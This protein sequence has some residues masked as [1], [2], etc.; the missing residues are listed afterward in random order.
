MKKKT[1]QKIKIKKTNVKMKVISPYYDFFNP[2]QNVLR[3]NKKSSKLWQG[4]KT[5]LSAN[6]ENLFL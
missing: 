6:A 1:E 4:Q 3:K 2:M 5:F